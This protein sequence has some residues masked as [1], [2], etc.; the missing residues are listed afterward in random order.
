[1]V[2]ESPTHWPIKRLPFALVVVDKI[3]AQIGLWF[4]QCWCVFWT[5]GNDIDKPANAGFNVEYF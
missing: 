2:F 5:R 3:V 4:Q 1:M